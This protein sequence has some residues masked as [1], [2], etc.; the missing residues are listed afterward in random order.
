M[1]GFRG[2]KGLYAESAPHTSREQ[3]ARVF[4]ELGIFK[5]D[6]PAADEDGDDDGDG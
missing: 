5:C 3:I 4:R 1:E 2:V 6:Y